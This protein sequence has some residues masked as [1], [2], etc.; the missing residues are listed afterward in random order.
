MDR[1]NRKDS[2]DLAGSSSS[3]SGNALFDASQYEFFG[4]ESVEEVELGGLDELN[5][6]PRI[7]FSNDEYQLFEKDEGAGLGSLSD[8]D[9][10]A[11]TFFKLNKV[12]TGPRNPGVI[13]D[14]GSG[15]F[16]R[17]SK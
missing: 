6:L 2:R 1:S 13:G 16:S 3:S 9:D 14:R 12:V 7:G 5:D 10:L 17:E 11:S 8:M 4:Q 15:S